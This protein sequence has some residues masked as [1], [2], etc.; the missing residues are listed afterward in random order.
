MIKGQNVNL[1][2]V[3]RE[4][5]EEICKLTNDLS[6][7]GE[8]LDETLSPE[9]LFKKKYEEAGFWSDNFGLM[10]ITDKNDRII[11][12]LVYFKCVPYLPGYEIGYRLY[13][14]EDRGKGYTTEAVTMFVNYLFNLKP[15]ERL[16]IHIIKG[17]IASRK[18]AEKCGF[19]YE[20]LKRQAIFSRGRYCDLESFAIIR[21]DLV[22]LDENK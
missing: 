2:T 6:Q 22:K 15:I 14:T 8:F 5:L 13:R 11:G 1:R 12:E 18:V 16:E 19:K 4:D 9:P 10:V 21:N 3:K 7:R 20:G 17:N